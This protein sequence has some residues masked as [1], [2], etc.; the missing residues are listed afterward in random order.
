[1]KRALFTLFNPDVAVE[2]ARTLIAAGWE[3][4][5]TEETR[6]VLLA[7]G[8]PCVPV[9]TFLECCF[10]GISFPPTLHPRME[11][12]L[13]GEGEPR[14]D[15]VF[16]MPYPLTVGDDVGGHTL[17]ALAAKG[18]RLPVSNEE[19]MSLTCN[20]IL[21]QGDVESPWRDT[22]IHRARVLVGKHF[23]LQTGQCDWGRIPGREVAMLYE[24]ENPYQKPAHLFTSDSL[25]TL[26]LDQFRQISG[27]APCFTDIADMDAA[28]HTLVL[29]SEAFRRAVG[30]VP[31][32][33][34]VAKHGNAC[35]MAVDDD[36]GVCLDKALFGNPRAAWG[37]ECVVNFPVDGVLGQ[38]LLKSSERERCLGD[39]S[40][41]LDIVAA[42]SFDDDAVELL[43]KRGQ[44]KL[45]VNPEL[46]RPFLFSQRW[47]RREVR[48][49]YL[50][51]PPA[52]YIFELSRCEVEGEVDQEI[53]ADLILAWAV[54]FSGF[55]GGNEISL[56]RNRGLICVG[57]GPAPVDAVETALLRCQAQGFVS[58][59]SVFA[60]DAFFPHEDGPDRLIEAKVRAGLVPA[61]GMKETMVRNRFRE[62][63]VVVAYLPEMYRGFC[64]H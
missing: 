3:I 25:D 58:Q 45:L 63:G 27:M 51:Q 2:P 23:L 48:G 40:W 15:L 64:R 52:H 22:L 20:Q 56:V 61:G 44:Q 41:M 34:V 24:G 8:L 21:H 31:N 13:T 39:A 26:A 5:V 6:A 16:V 36:P 50:R 10:P 12:A 29:A 59:G 9:E 32:L 38:K 4:V 1:M 60:A 49:G 62:A 55:H 46:A 54:S 35:G 37:G 53:L 14:L 43:G 28:V 18:G 11:A 42:P 19:D 47:Q 17:L 7:A 33:A 57:G 30:R